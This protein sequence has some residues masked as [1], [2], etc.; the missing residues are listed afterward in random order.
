MHLSLQKNSVP[1][2][3]ESKMDAF[4]EFCTVYSKFVCQ[5]HLKNDYLICWQVYRFFKDASVLPDRLHFKDE[6]EGDDTSSSGEAVSDE[7]DHE[8]HIHTK[9]YYS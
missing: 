4:S 2:Q 7:F 5:E 1:D 6:N 9:T 3:N 8:E